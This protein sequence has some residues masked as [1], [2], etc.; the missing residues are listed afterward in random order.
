MTLVGRIFV[1]LILLF[2]LVFMSF[3][4]MVYSTHTNWRDVILNPQ[5]GLKPQLDR[6]R[7]RGT[8]L[9]NRLDALTKDIATERQQRDASLAALEAEKES[10][11][12]ERDRTVKEI[13]DY[14]QK[15]QTAA[16]AMEATQQ[17][18]AKLRGEI[19]VLRQNIR[20]VQ[21]DKE[22]Q[23]KQVVELTD[24]LFQSQGEEDRLKAK[25]LE[26]LEQV[27]RQKLV[28][29]RHSLNEFEPVDGIPPKMDGIVLAINDEGFV[30]ISLGADDGL[31]KGHT[32]EVYRANKYLGRIEVIDSAPDKAVAKIVPQYRQGN[33]Q[34]E[35]RVAT[36]LN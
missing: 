29:D 6:E 21:K 18:L 28:L 35:D 1:V 25:N 19:D 24:K 7:A 22:D 3:A 14:V 16:A 12:E 4:T 17:T 11:R 23:F 32:L 20:D 36:R 34:K 13:A 8:E 5:T 27:G 26:L 9:Q 33:I 30:E 2:S 31:R 10:L 15:S